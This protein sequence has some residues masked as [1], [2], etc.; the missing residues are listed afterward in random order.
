MFSPE[1]FSSYLT[2]ELLKKTKYNIYSNFIS[3]VNYGQ[4]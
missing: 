3:A 4:G 2:L 1:V